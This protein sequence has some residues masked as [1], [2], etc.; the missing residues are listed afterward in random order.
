MQ[1]RAATLDAE[2][3]TVQAVLTTDAPTAVFDW[4][5]LSV[6]DEVL[7]MGGMQVHESRQVPFLESHARYATDFVI[8]SV[9]GVATTD[10]EAVGVIHF[11]KSDDAAAKVFKKYEEGHLTDVSVGYRVLEYEDIKPGKTVE[12]GGRSYTAG[13]RALR[14]TTKWELKEVSAVA[15][16]ADRNAKV[17]GDDAPHFR[18]AS[19]MPEKNEDKGVAPDAR[20]ED[21]PEQSRAETPPP[22]PNAVSKAKGDGAIAE[23]ERITA[24]TDMA[25][26]GN[27]PDDVLKAAI[28]GEDSVA[29]AGKRFWD[30]KT[31]QREEPVGQPPAGHVVQPAERGALAAALLLRNGIDLKHMPVKVKAEDGSERTLVGDDAEKLRQQFGNQADALRGMSSFDFVRAC[32]AADGKR[33]G[34]S[35]DDLFRAASSSGTLSYAF[36]TSVY[37]SVMSGYNEFAD[38]T[39]PFVMEVEVP[40][41]QTQT[42]QRM[43]KGARLEKMTRGGKVAHEEALDTGE[44]FSIARYADQFVIDEMDII[45][46]RLGM[47][48]TGP[49]GTPQQMGRAAMRLRPDLVYSKLLENPTLTDTGALFNS[50]ALSTAGGHNNLFTTALSESGIE[51]FTKALAQA[52]EGSGAR[53][54]RLRLRLAGLIVPPDLEFTASRLLGSQEV[55]KAAQDQVST[56]GTLNVISRL[57]LTLIVEPNIDA[58]GVVDP[59][60]GAAQTARTGSATNYFGF[61]DQKELLVAYRTGT[62]RSPQVRNG[63]LTQGQW[64]MWFDIKHDIGVGL[65]GALGLTK[66]TGTVAAS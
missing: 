63:M 13:K 31:A 57:G 66:S 5:T 28:D 44:T 7:S 55:R 4:N 33:V 53:R 32:L 6:V 60:T 46:D 56:Y 19:T 38:T 9:R 1:V 39:T 25:R 51:D 36:D 62:G 48:L 52:Y 3:M 14:V 24:L 40:N 61:A 34:Y 26:K 18:E 20:T 29:Q 41:F 23:R 30:W 49:D 17:R 27:V 54:T 15:I 11:S 21:T 8:G 64:G 37:A 22:Q 65:K 12:I 50:T 10:S 47:I 16:G 58:T 42:L 59:S 2:A 35:Q 43:K 45:D